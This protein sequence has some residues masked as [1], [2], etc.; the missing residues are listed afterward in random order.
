MKTALKICMVLALG[1][2]M[3]CV[4]A[5]TAISKDVSKITKAELTSMMG[6]PD[7]IILDVRPEQQWKSSELKIRGAVY[8]NPNKVGSWAENY[9]KDKTLIL[10]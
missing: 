5:Q 6:S 4:S 9:P 10:Y 2:S 3:G 1:L 8:E 7:V